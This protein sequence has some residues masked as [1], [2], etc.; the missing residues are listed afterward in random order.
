[1]K[2]RTFFE[3]VLAGLVTLFMLSCSDQKEIVKDLKIENM[4]KTSGVEKFALP[5]NL[6]K[7]SAN[8]PIFHVKEQESISIFEPSPYSAGINTIY[9]CNSET[10]YYNINGNT[11]R[12]TEQ[13]FINF[14]TNK[15]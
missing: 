9:I 6:T 14:I 7:H 3:L 11:Y 13:E 8:N 5:N 15:Q 10:K 12:L 2:T 4:K 1:M